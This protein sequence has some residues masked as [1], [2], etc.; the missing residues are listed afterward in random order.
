MQHGG[1]QKANS[2]SSL[3]HHRNDVLSL[4]APTQITVMAQ[5]DAVPWHPLL[6]IT[7]ADSTWKKLM[8]EAEERRSARAAGGEHRFEPDSDARSVGKGQKGKKKE[9][10]GDE[11]SAVGKQVI[12]TE[13]EEEELRRR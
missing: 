2:V 10:G 1:A 3:Q 4:F 9:G 12:E 6:S 7:P 11:G 8:E 13:L 5:S